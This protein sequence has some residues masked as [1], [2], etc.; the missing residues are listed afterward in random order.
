MDHLLFLEADAITLCIGAI[1]QTSALICFTHRKSPLRMWAVVTIITSAWQITQWH[2]ADHHPLSTL[3]VT[4]FW[5]VFLIHSAN[6]LFVLK[7]DATDL[8]G[9][10]V[11]KS[12]ALAFCI[13]LVVDTRATGT[14]WQLRNIYPFPA[15]YKTY[16]PNRE[17]FILR[18]V[19]IFIWQYLLL[20]LIFSR[21]TGPGA[22]IDNEA[23]ILWTKMVSLILSPDD[24]RFHV[25]VMSSMFFYMI[26]VR[27]LFDCI[28]R[29]MT[30]LAV[31][32]DLCPTSACY[33]LF[34][35]M[36]DAYTLRNFFSKFWHQLI[37]WPFGTLSIFVIKDVLCIR[38]PPNLQRRLLYLFIF[39]LS[40][41]MHLFSTTLTGIPLGNLGSIPF[42]SLAIIA[43]ILE[44]LVVNLIDRRVTP[45]KSRKHNQP[46]RVR[47]I[48]Y[49][50]VL[51][52]LG[53]SSR[54]Y[55]S[56]AIRQFVS[57]NASLPHSFVEAYGVN[58]VVGVLCIWGMFLKFY[59]Q[60]SL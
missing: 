60:T 15:Y 16:P 57:L 58:P 7:V 11:E 17:D 31:G 8:A 54:F 22:A 26:L 40:G 6:M 33:P 9:P 49:I 53:I 34:G 4:Y 29:A 52:A 46:W 38:D 10:Q 12:E 51:S 44:T 45:L 43:I 42:F 37:Q 25:R 21:C 32:L 48:G 24:E 39:A 27:V 14:R 30:I 19:A 13:Q 36:W 59:Y 50:W 18:Q 28:C 1:L 5:F 55:T 2:Q 3:L 23:S 47:I 35:S 41:G 56:D 20:D